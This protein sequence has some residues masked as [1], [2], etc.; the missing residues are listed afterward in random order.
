MEIFWS[1]R[2]GETCD[3]VMLCLTVATFHGTHMGRREGKGE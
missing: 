3:F 1:Q 2:C